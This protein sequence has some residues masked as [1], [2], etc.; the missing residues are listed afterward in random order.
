MPSTLWTVLPKVDKDKCTGCGACANI[1]PK[2][3]IMI[4]VEGPRKPVV[5]CSNKDKGSCG[6]EGLHHLLHCLRY[7]RAHL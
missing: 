7:V 1:C 4:D 5:M 6:H 3:V 2:Q